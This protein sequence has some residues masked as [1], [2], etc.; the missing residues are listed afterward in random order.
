MA[1]SIVYQTTSGATTRLTPDQY[2]NLVNQFGQDKVDQM[3]NQLGFNRAGSGN[4]S[5]LLDY[6]KELNI[7]FTDGT[8]DYIIESFL[9][10]RSRKNAF[11]DSVFASQHQYQW[12][13][14][15]LKKPVLIHFLLCLV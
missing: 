1:D 10:E 2:G 6:A 13:V 14:D 8:R 4:N 15:D 11:A 5:A 9:N 3:F 12:L 7:P